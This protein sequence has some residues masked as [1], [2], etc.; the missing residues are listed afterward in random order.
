M[1]TLARKTEAGAGLP[2]A[3]SAIWAF[4][5]LRLEREIVRMGD[6]LERRIGRFCASGC[7]LDGVVLEAFWGVVVWYGCR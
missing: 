4:R 6:S 5:R 7:G 1:M 3:V 2:W